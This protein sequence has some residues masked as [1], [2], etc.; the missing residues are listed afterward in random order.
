MKEVVAV[1]FDCENT[2]HITCDHL[3]SHVLIQDQDK[4]ETSS[5]S[6]T[7]DDKHEE[8]PVTDEQ[9]VDEIKKWEGS[10]RRLVLVTAGKAGMGKSTLL[11]NLL[12]LTGEKAAKSKPGA[13]SVTKTV[14]YYEEEVHGIT[15]R[16]IDTP[17]LESKDLSSE[18]EQE[19]LATLSVFS[20]GKVDLMLY[21]MALVGRFD[22]SDE[23]IVKKLTTAFGNEIWRH[24]ILVLTFGDVVLNQDEGDRDLLEG[25]TNE[26]EQ[27]LKK[28]GVSDVPVKSI[29]SVQDVDSEFESALEK[30]QQ[31]EIIGIPVGQHTEKPQDWAILLFKEIIKKCKIDAIPAMLVVQGITPH[32]VAEVLKVAGDVS[33]GT[34]GGVARFVTGAG[35]GLVAGVLGGVVGAVVGAAFGGIGAIPG[36]ALGAAKGAGIG[37]AV[38]IGGGIAINRLG[39]RIFEGMHA[40]R[41]VEELTGLVM[42]LKARQRVEELQAAK[43]ANEEKAIVKRKAIDNK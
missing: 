37:A 1:V 25:F 39:G 2:I 19:A 3:V 20:D 41:L 28:A 31:P 11:N 21:C 14:D 4:E 13:K 29:L 17:G 8:Q 18:E 40:K 6:A 9:L 16:I 15:V 26:F 22:D 23:R 35:P 43:K 30:V 10:K 24:A 38:G 12:G 33:A 34:A 5:C 7:T 36:A 27:V 42:I 32:W